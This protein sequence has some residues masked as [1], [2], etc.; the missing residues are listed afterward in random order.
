MP[1]LAAIV[2]PP[3]SVVLRHEHHDT[4]DPNEP[5]DLVGITCN[6]PIARHVYALADAFRA[7][8]RIVVLGGP[9]AT[10]LPEEPKAHAVA[11]VVGEA[12]ET[13]PRLLDDAARG[14]LAP[15]YRS[16]GAPARAGLPHARRD[17]VHRRNLLANTLV[18]PCGCPHRCSD[19]DRRQ[20]CDAWIRDRPVEEVAA[21]VRTSRTPCFTF[22]DEQLF[23]H[24]R[25][26]LRLFAGLEGAAK[27]WA[28]M[29]TLASAMNGRGDGVRTRDIQPGKPE[30]V[31][32]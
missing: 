23:M 21:E 32:R 4:L 7:R 8:G 10:L 26:A 19:C 20:T 2:R 6:T 3:P 22:W 18:A 1:D 31:R 5:A 27:R 9:H 30:A 15:S 25:Y 14:S 12:E 11:V 29:V 24:P 17:R 28:A 16:A 13:W